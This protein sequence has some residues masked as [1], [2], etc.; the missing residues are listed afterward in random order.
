MQQIVQ[1]VLIFVAML[2]AYEP[3][4]VVSVFEYVAYKTRSAFAGQE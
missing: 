3:V 4:A 2:S 1:D